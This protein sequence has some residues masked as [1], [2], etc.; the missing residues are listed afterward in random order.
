MADYLTTNW[1]EKIKTNPVANLILNNKRHKMINLTYG[2]LQQV[3]AKGYITSNWIL[4]N[5]K[6]KQ[7]L[8]MRQETYDDNIP[9]MLDPKTGNHQTM[10]QFMLE[11]NR[12]RRRAEIAMQKSRE[13]QQPIKGKGI[14]GQKKS[15]EVRMTLKDGIS[16]VDARGDAPIVKAGIT[17]E[18]DTVITTT[19]RGNDEDDENDQKAEQLIDE[20]LL[21]DPDKAIAE[22]AEPEVL[23]LYGDRA[24]LAFGGEQYQGGSMWNNVYVDNYTNIHHPKLRYHLIDLMSKQPLAIKPPS[25]FF[26]D[27]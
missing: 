2:H 27:V 6:G 13:K 15:K 23:K 24:L 7:N 9:R 20:D 10:Q 5:L 18:K 16:D 14:V 19:K 11:F 26:S 25:V 8:D 22:L 4:Q 17:Q 1:T 3:P 12:G 21:V